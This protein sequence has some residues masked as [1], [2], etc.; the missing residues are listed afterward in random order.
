[1][2]NILY[3]SIKESFD[4]APPPNEVQINCP[5][6]PIERKESVDFL[7]PPP[8]APPPELAVLRDNKDSKHVKNDTEDLYSRLSMIP[9]PDF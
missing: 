7:P 5:S 4:F 2:N 9:E 8:D 6:T 1:M 3:V